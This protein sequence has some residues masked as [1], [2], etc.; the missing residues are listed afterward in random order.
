MFLHRAALFVPLIGGV[1]WLAPP[2]HAADA[3]PVPDK[4]V[5]AFVDRRVREW[6]PTAAEKR[7]DEIG[8]CTSLLQAE[9]TAKKHWRPIFLFTHDGKMQVGRC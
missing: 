4:D 8:W 2:L 5:K 7:F 3:V 9:E 6:Q 1:L